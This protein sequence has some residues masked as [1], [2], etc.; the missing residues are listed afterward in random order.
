MSLLFPVHFHQHIHDTVLSV[1][2]KRQSA[3][4]DCL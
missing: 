1:Q 4:E 3:K 2:V